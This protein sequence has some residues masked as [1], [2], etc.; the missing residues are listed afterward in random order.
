MSE[1]EE[2]RK[3]ASQGWK[4][5]SVT[6]TLSVSKWVKTERDTKQAWKEGWEPEQEG[7]HGFTAH[8]VRTERERV[9]SSLSI[10]L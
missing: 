3:R 4:T 7:V 10:N 2:K 6:C 8:L 9:T 1:E 5:L